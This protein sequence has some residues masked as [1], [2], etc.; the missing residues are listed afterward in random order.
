MRVTYKDHPDDLATALTRF[1]RPPEVLSLTPRSL[2]EVWDDVRRVGEA[3]VELSTYFLTH[4]LGLSQHLNQSH[5]AKQGLRFWFA[6]RATTAL[7][8]CSEIG[9]R[10]LARV[11]AF[12]VDRAV[13][14]EEV[15]ARAGD[16]GAS[17]L[18]PSQVLKVALTA[19]AQWPVIFSGC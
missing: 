19:G 4:C 9:G 11:P 17:M 8:E 15:L 3:T 5:L 18:R 12:Q 13:L 6:N 2:D 14:D 10:Y 7:D 16:L 1:Q